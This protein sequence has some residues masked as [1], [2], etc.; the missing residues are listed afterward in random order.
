MMCVL[1]LFAVN[2]Q[3]LSIVEIGADKNPDYEDS[4]YLPVYDYASY[5]ISQQ[6]YTAE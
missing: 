6:I 2:A 3:N 5:A 1:G 4:Y